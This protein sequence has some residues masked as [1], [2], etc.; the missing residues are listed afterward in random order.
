MMQGKGL[1]REGR[2][3]GNTVKTRG[4]PSEPHRH[5]GGEFIRQISEVPSHLMLKFWR[6]LLKGV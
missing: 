4:G 2:R 5:L 3:E 1:H 6:E